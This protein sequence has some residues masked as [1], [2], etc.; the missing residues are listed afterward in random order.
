MRGADRAWEPSPGG[1]VRALLPLLRQSGGSWVGWTGDVDDA[2]DPFELD[3]VHLYPVP[4]SQAEHDDYYEGFANDSLW[5]LYH[6][7]VRD[8]TFRAA[9]WDAYVAV[10]Q[11][12]ADKLAAVAPPDAIIWVH[13]YHLQLV[14]AMVRAQR[15]DATIGF[16]LHIPFPPWELFSRLPWRAEII[17]G[18]LGADLV[19]F[20]RQVGAGNFVM[21]AR[22]LHE[23]LT[24]HE[25]ASEA[26]R[27]AG[28]EYVVTD[29]TGHASTVGVFP[30]S[31]DVAELDDLAA[32][33]NVR[34][35][36]TRGAHAA[37][38]PRG[39]PARRRPPRLHQG[40]RR[41]G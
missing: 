21:I 4:L 19:G 36:A 16:F 11:R 5:P 3:G 8:S 35:A 1:L 14:P 31:I 39:D 2:P 34:R 24:V 30:I 40:D 25:L 26:G 12:F 20:Q 6:D 37:R 32:Q 13:D 15:P 7:A 18:M 22:Q 27:Q 23:E 9:Q 38:Q 28:R 17:E 41:C 10:N 29:S 33:R